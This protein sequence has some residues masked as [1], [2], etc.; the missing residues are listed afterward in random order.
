MFNTTDTGI[1]IPSAF[2]VDKFICHD[3]GA[4]D[5]YVE[6]AV[7][8]E[9]ICR[10]CGA[11]NAERCC[12]DTLSVI[13]RE[14]IQKT[15]K[16]IHHFRYFNFHSTFTPTLTFTPLLL[17]FFCCLA[18]ECRNFV[19]EN[20]QFLKNYWILLKILILNYF[21]PMK[22]SV[23]NL[24]SNHSINILSAKYSDL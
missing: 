17:N 19:V 3:C 14:I 8:G 9:I 23:K 20:L 22:P 5:D 16:K 4:L 2:I 7:R 10:S 13:Q 1:H 24:P 15:Y 11:V 6:D 18:R 12:I 21:A